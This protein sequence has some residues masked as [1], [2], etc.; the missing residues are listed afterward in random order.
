MSPDVL[1]ADRPVV[2]IERI[3]S[4]RLVRAADGIA[5]ALGVRPGMAASKAQAL[6]ANVVMIDDDPEEDRLSLDR[7]AL[8]LLRNYTPIVTTDGIDG[9]V[10]DTEGADH[11][12]GGEHLMLSEIVNRLRGRGLSARAAVSDTWGASHAIARASSE[13]TTVVPSGC[14]KDAVVRLSVASLRLDQQTVNTLRVLGIDTVAELAALPRANL[15]LRFGPEPGR[16]LDQMFGRTAEPIEPIR[17]PEIVEVHHSFAEPIGAAETIAKYV[18]RLVRQLCL[19]LETK[20]LGVKRADLLA[21][22]V[23]NSVQS[24]R[25]GTARPVR[26]QPWLIKLL[27]DRIER[28]DPGFG[29]E[30]LSLAAIVAEPLWETQEAT[31]L[32]DESQPEI[33]PLVDVLGNRG[34][35]LYRLAPF[36]SDVPERSVQ[37]LPPLAEETGADWPIGWPRPARLLA[38]PEE[39]EVLALLPDHPPVAITW[40]GKRRHVRVADGPE[41]IFGE[42]WRRDREYDAVRDYYIVEDDRGERLW[43]FRS[44]DGVDGATGSR[45]WFVHGIFG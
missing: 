36:P 31:D 40:R 34:Q 19:V 21:T 29:I 11:L 22:R 12:R 35:R 5:R 43:I 42:W 27:C 15:A 4:R 24:L 17:P 2:V 44:G 28:I 30:R 26:D 3:G 16:R 6:A 25:I 10:M 18:R 7:L 9:L 13:E 33:G 1:P 39:I 45:K 37:V 8:W 38:K 41:R 14:V 32:I 20:A 23:D